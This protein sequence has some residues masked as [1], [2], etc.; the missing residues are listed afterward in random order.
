MDKKQQFHF[1][2]IAAAIGA[3]LLFQ[4]WWTTY[5]TVEPLDY[6]EFQAL[7]KKGDVE[8]AVSHLQA[9][10]ANDPKSGEALSGRVHACW[11]NPALEPSTA[12]A[13][14]PGTTTNR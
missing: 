13:S 11:I 1:W 2:Y 12:A 4:G 5:K 10:V 7:L 8:G 6:S 3:V 14:V 9:A